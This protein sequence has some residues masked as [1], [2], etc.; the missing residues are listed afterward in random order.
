MRNL[1][2]SAAEK[3]IAR[4]AFDSALHR[5]LDAVIREA[6]ERAA[7]VSLVA[8]LWELERWLTQRRQEIDRTYDYRYSVLPVVFRNLIR[9]GRLREQ[10]LDGLAEDKLAQI[11]WLEEI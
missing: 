6:K 5:E 4:K 2:W 9:Q 3:A 8:D 1:K 7:R 11:R 10:E